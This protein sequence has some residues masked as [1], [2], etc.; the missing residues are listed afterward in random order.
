MGK[1]IPYA[2]YPEQNL[3]NAA[4]NL[5]QSQGQTV[6]YSNI[7]NPN[8]GQTV[9]YNNTNLANSNVSNQNQGQYNLNSSQNLPPPPHID[10]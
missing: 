9:Q 7:S 1:P 3:N 4:T 5:A 10:N 2:V 8:Q 6:Q